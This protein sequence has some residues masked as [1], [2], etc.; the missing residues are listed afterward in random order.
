M[1]R[2]APTVPGLTTRKSNKDVHPGNSDKPK[3][4]KSASD[5]KAEKLAK[6]KDDKARATARRSKLNVLAKLED[7]LAA[8]DEC[9]EL[10]LPY[11]KE[12]LQPAGRAPSAKQSSSK[13]PAVDESSADDEKG[14]WRQ[15]R[16]LQHTKVTGFE[17]ARLG[18]GG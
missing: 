6:V 18:A 1:S 11:R 16:G 4:Q 3:A 12:S 2:R 15:R 13:L 17:E 8:E 5:V 7:K 9:G 10:S 14:K